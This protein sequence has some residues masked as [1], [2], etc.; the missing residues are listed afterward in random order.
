ML[1]ELFSVY[2]L[3]FEIGAV[4]PD[5]AVF[6]KAAELAGCRPEEIF[7]ADD[8]PG[9]VA[10]RRAWVLMPSCMS[11]RPRLLTELRKRGVEINY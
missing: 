8:M 11:Q 9:H 10:G 2:A 3:S 4:K 7:Y 5:A 6:C 1:R